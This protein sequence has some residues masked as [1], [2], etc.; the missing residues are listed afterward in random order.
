MERIERRYLQSEIID[1]ITAFIESEGLSSGEK[2]PSQAELTEML[3][4]SRTSLREAMKTLEARN[5]I[6]IVNGKGAFV[7][8]RQKSFD[9]ALLKEKEMVLELLDVRIGLEQEII[10]LV[11]DKATEEELDQIE[12]KLEV[13]M[14]RHA[15]G[16]IHIPEDKEFHHLIYQA[17]HNRMLI[18]VI[19]YI[20]KNFDIIWEN[21]LGMAEYLSNTTPLHKELFDH[22]KNRDARHA[23]MV[24]SKMITEIKR[25]VKNTY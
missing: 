22:L 25:Y 21:P 6:E 11:V 19:S 3:G 14:R 17:C 8:S 9:P 7:S 13:M 18:D 23:K 15:N 12:K 20:S 2:L 16:E 1:R 24:N 10:Q 4:V 5:I